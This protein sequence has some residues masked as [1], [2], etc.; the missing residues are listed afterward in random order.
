MNTMSNS[1]TWFKSSYSAEA[2]SSCVEVATL[3]D[4]AWLVRDSKNAEGP[5]LRFSAA[6]W[7]RF[8]ASLKG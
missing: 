8:T 7:R 3:P 5:A 4:G 2:G 1:P 6:D